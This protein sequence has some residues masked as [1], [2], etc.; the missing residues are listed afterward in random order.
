M[1]KSYKSEE[2]VEFEK[3]IKFH[4]KSLL[5]MVI[6]VILVELILSYLNNN[7]ILI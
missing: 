4:F 3:L 7:G 2:V 5:I 1:N 6:L